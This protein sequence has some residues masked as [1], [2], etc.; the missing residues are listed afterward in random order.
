MEL[1]LQSLFGLHVHSCTHWLM[2]S[3]L[4]TTHLGSYTRALLVSQDRRHLFVTLWFLSRILL[5]E[6]YCVHKFFSE[7][8]ALAIKPFSFCLILV[9]GCV[10]LSSANILVYTLPFSVLL[11]EVRL[12]EVYTSGVIINNKPGD[13]VARSLKIQ[14]DCAERRYIL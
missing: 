7:V 8:K 13:R 10:I 12:Q 6:V 5:G 14:K 3:Q 4:L 1:D 2:P 11:A 9:K